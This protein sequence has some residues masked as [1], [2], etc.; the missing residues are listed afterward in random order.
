M[1][2]LQGNRP[3]EKV[4]QEVSTQ[5]KFFT[6]KDKASNKVKNKA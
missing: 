6:G 5:E 3:D 4:D 1:E 2:H